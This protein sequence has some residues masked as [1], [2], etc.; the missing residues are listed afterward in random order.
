MVLC[1]DTAQAAGAKTAEVIQAL[2]IGAIQ[3]ENRHHQKA[4]EELSRLHEK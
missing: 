4:Q 1:Y 3:R 2:H